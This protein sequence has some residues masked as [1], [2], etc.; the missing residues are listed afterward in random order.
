MPLE[1]KRLEDYVQKT[2]GLQ[3]CDVPAT[4]KFVK[5]YT[6]GHCREVTIKVFCEPET[7]QKF[8]QF[9]NSATGL[10]FSTQSQDVFGLASMTAERYNEYNRSM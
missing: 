1:G 8:F 7:K 2:Y 3:T 4:A 5:D 6:Y 9:C 10:T